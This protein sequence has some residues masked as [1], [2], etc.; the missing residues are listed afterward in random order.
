MVEQQRVEWRLQ[1]VEL[2]ATQESHL[3][4]GDRRRAFEHDPHR[5]GIIRK[6]RR[7]NGVVDPH[8]GG[9]VAVVPRHVLALLVGA[10]LHEV[11]PGVDRD[12]PPHRRHVSARRR[13][14]LA[15]D[16]EFDPNAVGLD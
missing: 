6:P 15:G 13:E 16:I 1:E 14:D 4:E 10:G 7:P 9:R 2:L 12:R 11:E 5:T 8:V 3:Q